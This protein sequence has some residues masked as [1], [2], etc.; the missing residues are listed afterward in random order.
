M[1]IEDAYAVLEHDV[2]ISPAFA[3]E[4]V[5]RFSYR[6]PGQATS[7]FYGYTR[8]LDLRREVETTLGAGFDQR[9]FHDFILKQGLLPPDLMRSVVLKGFIGPQPGAG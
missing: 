3:K 7:Y 4:E 5:E 9:Q 8:L 6:A 1:T 2:V